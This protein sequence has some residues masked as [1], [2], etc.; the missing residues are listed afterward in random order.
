[1]GNE[2]KMN[3]KKVN[4]FYLTT[5]LV[6]IGV[7]A[8]ILVWSIYV[9]PPR[10]TIVEN[11]LLGQGMILIPALLFM[12]FS[13]EKPNDIL[14]FHKIKISSVFMIILFTY[15]MM[16]VTT[17]IN[18][19]SM[20]FVD[21]TVAQMSGEVLQMPWYIM[22]PLMGMLGPLSEEIIFRGLVLNGYKKSG[23]TFRACF[24]S[25]LLFGLMHMNFNQAAYAVFLGIVMAVVVE[26]T[27]SLWGSVIF[28]MTVNIQNVMLMFVSG[29]F[30]SENYMQEAQ[31]LMDSKET[32]LAT[33][34]VYGVIAMAATAIAVCV[35]AWIARN[36]KR[37]MW[38]RQIWAGRKENRGQIVSVPLILGI[39]LSVAYMIFEV[40]VS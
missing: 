30:S 2:G 25:A 32:L 33:I 15:L 4:W 7:I 5:V 40:I 18:A 17:V 35:L 36:E 13:R 29:A 28:H 9:R 8:G 22:L 27:G 38:L 14:G 20:L 1:M 24:W 26:A 37:D 19:I 23:N 10:I 16:P 31:E 11:L 12:I 6:H 21:N 3:S 34:G 39:V